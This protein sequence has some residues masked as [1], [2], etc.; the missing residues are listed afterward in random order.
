MAARHH[1]RSCLES[2][3]RPLLLARRA[4]TSMTTVVTGERHHRAG[5]RVMIAVGVRLGSFLSLDDSCVLSQSSS[6]ASS[7]GHTPWLAEVTRKN[8]LA[9]FVMRLSRRPKRNSYQSK[10]KK[11]KNSHAH[12][13]TL[14]AVKKGP[15]PFFLTEQFDASCFWTARV[16]TT[17]SE[18]DHAQPLLLA[19]CTSCALVI[20][21]SD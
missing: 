14:R 4:V 10:R 15:D 18:V 6:P 11:K 12:F 19:C 5:S 8:G 13:N 7:G 21:S 17:C 16:G 1:P 20:S 2:H 3:G 9:T